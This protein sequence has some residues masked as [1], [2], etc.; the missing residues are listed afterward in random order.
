MVNVRLSDTEVEQV[1]ILDIAFDGF[2]PAKRFAGV[3][4][5]LVNEWHFT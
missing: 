1:V 4:Q 3:C 2:V 5:W